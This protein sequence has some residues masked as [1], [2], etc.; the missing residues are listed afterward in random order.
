MSAVMGVS[1]AGS[2]DEQFLVVQQAIWATLPISLA[3]DPDATNLLAVDGRR[4]DWLDH[5]SAAV[6]AG[7]AGVLVVHPSPDPPA[8][9]VREAAAAAHAAGVVVAVETTWASHPAV[10]G[11][12]TMVTDRLSGAALVDSVVAVAVDDERSSPTVLLDQLALVRAVA[13]PLDSVRFRADSA[14]GY[15]IGASRGTT[16]VALSAVRSTTAEPGARVSVYGPAGEAHLR[17]TADGTAAPASASFVDADGETVLPTWYESASRA[18]WRRLHDAVTA[19]AGVS[20]LALL[21]DDLD[22]LA[23]IT[24]RTGRA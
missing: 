8:S 5:M 23:S 2:A 1:V 19:Q 21:A 15:S 24:S 16:T 20:D 6:R 12:A 13:G 11:V 10:P 17:V 22:L 18:S 14:H 7:V 3:P 9:A 4:V